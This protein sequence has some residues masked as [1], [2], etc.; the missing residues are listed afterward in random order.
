MSTPLMGLASQLL[1]PSVFGFMI[2]F[3]PDGRMLA[4]G[5]YDDTVRL[6]DAVTGEE[7]YTITGHT[8]N[9]NSV[10]FSPDGRTLASGSDGDMVRLWAV[11]TGEEKHTITGYTGGVN[12]VA[13]SPDGQTL[14]S[15]S[16]D[17]TIRLWNTV[18]G[19]HMQTFTVFALPVYSIAFS[20]DGRTLASGGLV[21]DLWDTV[22]GEHIR[23]LGADSIIWRVVFSPDG[24]TLASGSVDETTR[25]WDVTTG[26]Q[27]GILTGHTGEISDV[28]FSS[29]GKMLASG[30]GD[31]TVI[32]WKL[33]STTLT[34]VPPL[35]EDVNRDGVV[36]ILDLIFV[37]S[38]FGPS[39]GSAADVNED[40]V[41]DIVDLV[42]VAS[43]LGNAGA[44]PS[45]QPQI[46]T[47]LITIDVQGWLTQAQN[48]D[49]TDTTLQRGVIFLEQLLA[50]LMPKE[51]SLLPN[52]P[53][54]FNPETWIPYQL[55][56]PVEVTLTIYDINGRLIRRLAVGHQAAGMY[57]SRSRAVYWDGRDQFGESVASGLYFYTLTVGKFTGSRKMLILK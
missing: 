22:T 48:L 53:N 52:Y 26:E 11:I 36:N 46:L 21:L 23:T 55:A 16:V 57:R 42:K 14:A 28:A 54:P 29:D 13:F 38:N 39:E 33:A 47:M 51:T 40:G 31:G 19:E 2:A 12:S 41:V 50:A 20:S 9:V 30:S 3:S 7:K 1:V 32:L 6:R 18:T 8:R 4:S 15:G 49:L 43:A 24:R 35:L 10:V 56:E 25:L 27:K 34:T 5:S 17:Q 45:A 37:A 44:A